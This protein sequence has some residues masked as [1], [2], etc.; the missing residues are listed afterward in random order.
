MPA[1]VTHGAHG[2]RAQDAGNK[3]AV[4][5]RA[6]RG[7]RSAHRVNWGTGHG[8]PRAPLSWKPPG[9]TA[10]PSSPWTLRVKSFSEEPAGF[11]ATH[12]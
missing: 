8:Q 10:Q 11:S 3:E 12:M 4:P 1:R 9:A 2:P 5:L 6:G 7:A